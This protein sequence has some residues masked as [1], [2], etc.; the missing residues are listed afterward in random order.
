MRLLLNPADHNHGFAEIRLGM[1]GGMG[2]RDKH[3]PAA[4]PLFPDII[5]DRRIA[6]LKLVLVAQPFKNALGGVALFTGT[7]QIVLH[8]LVDEAGETIQLGP[9]DLRRSLITGRD[10][11]HHHLLHARTRDPEM[12]GGLP[13][14]HTAPTREAD[15]QI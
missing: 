15:L 9:L 11:K 3:L 10:R 2:Q 5:L 13:F 6:A 1:A 4:P 7:V 14:A 12:A 8:P